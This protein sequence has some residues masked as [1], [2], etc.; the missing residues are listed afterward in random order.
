M[1]ALVGRGIA[2]VA[3]VLIYGWVDFLFYPESTILSGDAAVSQLQNS[4]V[5]YVT[6][7]WGMRFFGNLGIPFIGLLAVLAAIWWL[8][9]KRRLTAMRG[10]AV[11]LGAHRGRAPCVG[12]LRQKRLHRGDLHPAEP[13]GVR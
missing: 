3:A 13:I 11:L 12:L 1:N 9:A 6:S 5:A 8:P 10:A 7:I 4:D 2:T